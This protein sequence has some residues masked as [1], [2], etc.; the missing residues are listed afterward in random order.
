MA[1]HCEHEWRRQCLNQKNQVAPTYQG[2]SISDL[3]VQLKKRQ[4][5]RERQARLVCVGLL[6]SVLALALHLTW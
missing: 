4:A 5:A 6:P 3:Y 2:P 1:R